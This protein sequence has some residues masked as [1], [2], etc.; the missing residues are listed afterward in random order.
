MQ[1]DD[2][3]KTTVRHHLA[4]WKSLRGSTPFYAKMLWP[5]QVGNAMDYEP[6][7]T[8]FTAFPSIQICVEEIFTTNE[9]L[10]AQEEYPHLSKVLGLLLDIGDRPSIMGRRPYL[11]ELRAPVI[12]DGKMT[13][14]LVNKA[15]SVEAETKRSSAQ[16]WQPIEILK[17][18][19]KVEH[20]SKLFGDINIIAAHGDI[21]HYKSKSLTPIR[22]RG[23][24][25]V[26]TGGHFVRHVL[27]QHAIAT[28]HLSHPYSL[29][30]FTADIAS[31]GYDAVFVSGDEAGNSF[32]VTRIGAIKSIR[33]MDKYLGLNLPVKTMEVAKGS[34]AL[35]GRM[36]IRPLF[37][38]V[39]GIRVFVAGG[40]VIAATAQSNTAIPGHQT[41]PFVQEV[42]CGQDDFATGPYKMGFNGSVVEH[43]AFAKLIDKARVVAADLERVGELH[44]AMDVLLHE[45]GTFAIDL[46]DLLSAD[47]FS[48]APSVVATAVQKMVVDDMTAGIDAAQQF[49]FTELSKLVAL[50]PYDLKYTL[51]PQEADVS[52]GDFFEI[53]ESKSSKSQFACFIENTARIRNLLS[54]SQIEKPQPSSE[55]LFLAEWLGID[56]DCREKFDLVPFIEAL[57]KDFLER[58]PRDLQTLWDAKRILSMVPLLDAALWFKNGQSQT[59]RY[60]AQ[61]QFDTVVTIRPIDSVCSRSEQGAG[62]YPGHPRRRIQDESYDFRELGDPFESTDEIETGSAFTGGLNFRMTALSDDSDYGVSPTIDFLAQLLEDEK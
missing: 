50:M 5:P 4:N 57:R 34:K 9:V 26:R 13:F 11:K 53:D 8:G 38:A 18:A 45:D 2:Q 47:Y 58:A 3:L 40:K 61:N 56:D 15:F 49:S 59:W 17:F 28:G 29:S 41:E 43:Q 24:Y 30:A 32:S 46:Y 12:S 37:K 62:F 22:S 54:L 16:S 55:G 25:L 42:G 48:L 33:A 19:L 6:F 7:N 27:A 20:F 35:P 21:F 39:Q 51:D 44:Y 1:V 36:V 31:Q 52:A 10:R 14:D 60:C 23:S